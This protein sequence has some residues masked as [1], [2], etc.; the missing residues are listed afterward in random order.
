MQTLESGFSGM[1]KSFK[2][3][4]ESVILMATHNRHKVD[5]VKKV[6][7]M[8]A[9]GAGKNYTVAS[10]EIIPQ[11]IHLKENGVSFR[12]NALSKNISLFQWLYTEGIGSL[13]KIFSG[14][15]GWI[16]SDDSGLEVDALNGAPG[17]YS[18]RYAAESNSQGNAPDEE[19]NRKLLKELVNIT[20]LESRRGQ[21]R[22][23]LALTPIEIEADQSDLLEKTE[24]FEGI[25]RG[26]IACQPEG[27]NGFGYDP[28]FIP[29]GYN[30]S[31]AVLGENI[32]NK[33]SHRSRAL[34]ELADFL[35]RAER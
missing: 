21:F 7:S 17:I 9:G 22:C 3:M 1:S 16:L 2:E 28:L 31:F 13:E 34:A 24:F 10:L 35:K 29:E 27:E 25:C 11:K 33:I 8:T 5:E 32:K 14:G 20:T 19:N 4:R 6:L 15:K 30:K 18:A 26:R 23:L 12:E